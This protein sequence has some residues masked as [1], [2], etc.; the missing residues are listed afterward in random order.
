MYH[1]I[2]FALFVVELS[3][4]KQPPPATVTMEAGGGDLI[5][6]FL[7]IMY[8]VFGRLSRLNMVL[9]DSSHK[10]INRYRHIFR[11][12]FGSVFGIDRS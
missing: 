11:P 9:K 12:V 4:G 8:N 10:I 2:V 6:L 5:V 7:M 1:S 3:G